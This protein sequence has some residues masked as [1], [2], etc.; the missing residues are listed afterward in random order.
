MGTGSSNF[1]A[2]RQRESKGGEG[3]KWIRFGH[4]SDCI[5]DE[6]PD[7]WYLKRGAGPE[8]RLDLQL[9]LRSFPICAG[10][11]LVR[12]QGLAILFKILGASR[13]PGRRGNQQCAAFILGTSDVLGECWEQSLSLR[14]KWIHWNCVLVKIIIFSWSMIC[15]CSV[16]F[17][18]L[19]SLGSCD[20]F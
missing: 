8:C 1:S 20:S 4:F 11:G 16:V 18:Y 12:C 17:L 2:L 3:T 10:P 6:N 19:E 13:Y 9:T 5:S 7:L 14:M 15:Y